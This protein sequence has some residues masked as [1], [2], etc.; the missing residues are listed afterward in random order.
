MNSLY[1]ISDLKLNCCQ[2]WN[3]ENNF[4]YLVLRMNNIFRWGNRIWNY[5]IISYLFLLLIVMKFYPKTN[6]ESWYISCCFFLFFLFKFLPE[7]LNMFD[8]II[9]MMCF[10]T[11]NIVQHH[12]DICNFACAT[13][14]QEWNTHIIW[15]SK[16]NIHVK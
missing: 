3:E 16:P 10:S 15:M 7:S 1:H 4:D 13:R 2:T 8:I 11:V 9:V 6:H 12:V 5:N 14:K